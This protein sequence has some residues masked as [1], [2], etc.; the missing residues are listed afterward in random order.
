LPFLVEIAT[1]PEALAVASLPDRQNPRRPQIPGAVG[2]VFLV[3]STTCC[4]CSPDE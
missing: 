1:V 3:S 4:R 2:R